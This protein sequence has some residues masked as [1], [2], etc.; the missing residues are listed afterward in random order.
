MSLEIKKEQTFNIKAGDVLNFKGNS[1]YAKLIYIGNFLMY[2]KRGYSHSAIISK[3]TNKNIHVYEALNDGFVCSK[4]NK[5]KVMNLLMKGELC[6]G[7]P[8]Y[9]LTNV[10]KICKKYEGTKYGWFDIFHIFL[11]IILRKYAFK[12]NTNTKSLICSE[13]V[14]RILY[15]VS[16]KKMN[17]ET[18]FDKCYDLITPM[19]LFLSKQINW[20]KYL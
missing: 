19:D 15:D 11:Y 2:G 17:F 4:Y 8:K 20:R 10:S 18:E 13:A 5:N 1:N 16:S 14:C 12:L 7:R 9:R 6:L 3:V